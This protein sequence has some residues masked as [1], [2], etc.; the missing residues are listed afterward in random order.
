MGL[1]SVG[2]PL[3][4]DQ[5]AKHAGHVRENGIEQLICAYDRLKDRTNDCLRW[6]DEVCTLYP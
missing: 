3:P 5:A 4:W 6:G 1:L 2:T